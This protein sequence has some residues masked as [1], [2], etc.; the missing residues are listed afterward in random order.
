MLRITTYTR[1][2]LMEIFNTTR[3]DSIK[4][5]LDR[6]GY[7][8]ETAGRGKTYTLTI[9]ETPDPFKMFCINELG[10]SAQSDFTILRTFFYYFFCD[11]EFQS[12]PIGEMERIL[13]EEGKPITRKT[14]SK[15]IKYLENKAM[16]ERFKQKFELFKLKPT[17]DAAKKLIDKELKRVNKL[18]GCL[19]NP[20]YKDLIK[21]KL[22]R[23][24]K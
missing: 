1:E 9:T 22:K 11:E 7:K 21:E 19:I 15:W 8:Y 3:I 4:R 5:S 13:I 24:L 6:L 17:N 10:I 12:L 23:R 14:L 18:D 16:M 2:D 20:L